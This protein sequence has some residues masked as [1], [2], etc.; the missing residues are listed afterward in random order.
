MT[1]NCNDSFRTSMISFTFMN[2][3]LSF[4]PFHTKYGRFTYA[5]KLELVSNSSDT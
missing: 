5:D 3:A 1:P 2:N 4:P